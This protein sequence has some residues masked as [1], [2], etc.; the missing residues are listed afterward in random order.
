MSR[1][2]FEQWYVVN[3]FD[4]E[5]NPIGSRQCSLQWQAWQAATKAAKPKWI[6]YSEGDVVEDGWHLITDIGNQSGI[7]DVDICE[8]VGNWRNYRD[9]TVT[10]YMPLPAPFVPEVSE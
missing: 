5:K 3:A 7:I 8:Y 6:P 10:A 2:V 9:C 1:D 4:Y